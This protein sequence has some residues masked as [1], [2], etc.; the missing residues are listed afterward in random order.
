VIIGIDAPLQPVAHPALAAVARFHRQPVV[1]QC[2]RTPRLQSREKLCPLLLLERGDVRHGG[3]LVAV[4]DGIAV[5]EHFVEQR[6]L[7]ALPGGDAR[8][9][10]SWES[11][12]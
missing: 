1:A 10:G 2:I 3:A 9:D 11:V 12:P 4:G 7:A 6:A 8:A 5:A